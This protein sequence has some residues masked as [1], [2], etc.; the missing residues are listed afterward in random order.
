[1]RPYAV[2]LRRVLI[3]AVVVGTSL[4][5]S[6]DAAGAKVHGVSQAG[7]AHDPSGSGAN[8]SGTNSPAG[9]IPVTAAATG[10][11]ASG[12]A[13]SPGSGGDGDP[14]CDTAA[15]DGRQDR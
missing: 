8:Q 2:V 12:G 5:V 6:V 1:V 10:E 4:F 11:D 9:P 3:G 13:A 14:A 7:C 15:E